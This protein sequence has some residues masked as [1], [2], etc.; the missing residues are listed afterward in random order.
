MDPAG[1]VATAKAML[2]AVFAISRRWFGLLPVSPGGIVL[3]LTNTIEDSSEVDL[4]SFNQSQRLAVKSAV[5][6]TDGLALIWGPP[7]R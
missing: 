7:G 1:S 2:D 4:P 5:A 6:E 3:L